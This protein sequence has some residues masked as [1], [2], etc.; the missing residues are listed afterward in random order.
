MNY[1]FVWIEE[2][3]VWVSTKCERQSKNIVITISKNYWLCDNKY[4][5]RY[6]KM[7]INH[8]LNLMYRS[9]L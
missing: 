8:F 6:I 1:E 3:W 9:Y 4:S 7:K 2:S 5:T